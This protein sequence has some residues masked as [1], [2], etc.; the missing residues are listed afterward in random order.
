[1]YRLKNRM[2]G[3]LIPGVIFAL[4]AG[5]LHLF[6]LPFS[7][8]A[9]ALPII[10]SALYAWAGIMPAAIAAAAATGVMM[11]TFGPFMLWAVPLALVA[12]A[13]IN[14]Y[15]LEQGEPFF[16]R[17]RVNLFAQF[18]AVALTLSFAYMI[19]R[20]DLADALINYILKMFIDQPR[21]LL[22]MFL[23]G[24]AA[25][26]LT[27]F[28]V[29]GGRDAAQRADQLNWLL[30][31]LLVSLKHALPSVNVSSC[32][33]TAMLM[34]HWPALIRAKR[35]DMPS[36]GFMPLSE[37]RVP[38]NIVFS[39]AGCLAFSI[40]LAVSGVAG[41]ESLANVVLTA[42]Y[43]ILTIQGLS[44]VLRRM[45]AR[46]TARRVRNLFILLVLLFGDTRFIQILDIKGILRLIGV[47]ITLFGSGGA[48][49]IFIKKRENHGGDEG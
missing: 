2:P 43:M 36:E 8:F 24:M 14:I 25:M 49:R 17:L 28:A 5:V 6:L 7:M 9:L 18:L 23:D 4:I 26:G 31:R 39:A 47:Y 16:K 35:G 1:V 42:L 3:K 10:I 46:G 38:N 19:L 37:W 40:I 41:A 44:G 15:L 13:V 27:E 45:K 48:I 11:L 20:I 34:T 33:F 12:P 32:A 21:E 30:E 22:D 29:N